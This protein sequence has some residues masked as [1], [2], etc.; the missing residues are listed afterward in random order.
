[1]NTLLRD[2]RSW[3]RK[4]TGKLGPSLLRYT[5]NLA[6]TKDRAVQL[7]GTKMPGSA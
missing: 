1:M 7:E 6:G 4:S 5:N 2:I 3:Y